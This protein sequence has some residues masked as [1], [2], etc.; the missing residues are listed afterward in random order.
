LAEVV[1]LQLHGL[2]GVLDLLRKL[3][4]EVVSKGGGPVRRAA[5]KGI[6]VIRQQARANFRAA[7]AQAGITGITDTTG[8]TEKNIIAKRKAPR[9]GVKG[10]RYIL[11]VRPKKHPSGQ[12]LGKRVIQANDIAFIM[13]TGSSTQPATP[14]LRPAFAAKA[15]EAI[16]TVE[17][18]LPKEIDRIVRKLSKS[19]GGLG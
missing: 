19:G 12:K 5:F 16:R 15:E 6:K 4:P 14:W 2:D 18:E 8:F 7:V 1:T 9:G 11:T 13:E 3:P 10:E 17:R